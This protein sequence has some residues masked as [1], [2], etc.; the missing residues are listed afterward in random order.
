MEIPG[1]LCMLLSPDFPGMQIL[2][3]N[4]DRAQEKLKDRIGHT[5]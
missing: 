5:R 3:A 4:I 1:A 2:E